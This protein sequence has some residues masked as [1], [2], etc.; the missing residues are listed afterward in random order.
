MLSGW[1]GGGGGKGGGAK[2]QWDGGS[3]TKKRETM[4]LVPARG[5]KQTK[6]IGGGSPPG[7]ARQPQTKWLVRAGGAEEV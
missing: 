5:R 4:R 1:G 3:G 6:N 2:I 7:G